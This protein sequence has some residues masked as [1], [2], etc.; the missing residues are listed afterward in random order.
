MCRFPW[1]RC[2]ELDAPKEPHQTL[3]SS[4]FLFAFLIL[5]KLFECGG[6]SGRS[7]VSSAD[8]LYMYRGSALVYIL[9]ET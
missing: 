5:Y 2:Y 7:D 1:T 3:S 4:P 8:F 6:Q 9:D